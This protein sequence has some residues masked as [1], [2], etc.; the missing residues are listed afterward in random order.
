[1]NAKLGISTQMLS[2]KIMSYRRLKQS[3]FLLTCVIFYSCNTTLTVAH[4][5]H[6]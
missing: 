6:K 4:E 1:M 3:V 2:K 5:K